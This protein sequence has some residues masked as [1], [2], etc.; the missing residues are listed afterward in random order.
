MLP[1]NRLRRLLVVAGIVIASTSQS[2]AESHAEALASQVEIRRTQYGVPHIKADSLEAVAFGFG[3]CQAE[4]HLL[5]IMNNDKIGL[6][7]DTDLFQ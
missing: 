2:F 4:D 1:L 7:L 5:N 6:S 3:Y